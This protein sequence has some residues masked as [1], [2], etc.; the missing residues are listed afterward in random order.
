M[1]PHDLIV[2]SACRI[3]VPF[4]QLFALYV[5]AHGH[6]SPGGGFQG[7]VIL[8]ASIILFAISNDLRSSIKR[9]SEKTA[10]FLCMGGIFITPPRVF[11]AC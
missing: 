1:D 11:C 8:G 5:I 6:H 3:I 10:A 4:I 7:G 9:F 2:R